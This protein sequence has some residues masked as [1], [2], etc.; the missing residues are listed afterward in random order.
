M[1]WLLSP[2]DITAEDWLCYGPSA[3]P[4]VYPHPLPCGL[5]NVLPLIFLNQPSDLLWPM[6]CYQSWYKWK[7]EKDHISTLSLEL[8]LLPLEHNQSSKSQ[9][10][11]HWNWYHPK[12]VDSQPIPRHVSESSQNHKSV[13]LTYWWVQM[14]EQA[15]PNYV[16]P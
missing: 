4:L 6:G 16:E 7:L 12:S 13:Y 1:T 11:L 2:N 3:S 9:I 10:F 5:C 8:L 15:Q 14:H